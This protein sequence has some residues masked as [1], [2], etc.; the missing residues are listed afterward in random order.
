M[1]D[2]LHCIAEIFMLQSIRCSALIFVNMTWAAK[3]VSEWLQLDLP[4][5]L[6]VMCSIALDFLRLCI[7]SAVQLGQPNYETWAVQ[8][9]FKLEADWQHL[10]RNCVN[11]AKR[12]LQTW[13]HLDF[14]LQYWHLGHSLW[15]NYSSVKD[16]H[17]VSNWSNK[18]W[19]QQGALGLD[20]MS[21]S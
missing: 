10:F 16:W 6:L 3:Y 20:L 21:M 8:H 1:C 12:L 13:Q 15:A 14:F 4:C 2:M 17:S 11:F 9:R 18:A 5:E 7:R 19:I